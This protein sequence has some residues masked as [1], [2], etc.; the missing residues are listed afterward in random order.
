MNAI[1]TFL[2]IAPS[3]QLQ[4][5]KQAI[6]DFFNHSSTMGITSLHDC[7]L[8]A[9]DPDIDYPLMISIMEEH[10]PMRVSGYLVSTFWD[11]WHNEYKLKP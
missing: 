8:G 2:G 4:E 10:P 1:K 5:Y 3:I 6:I 9:I 11:K 7:G